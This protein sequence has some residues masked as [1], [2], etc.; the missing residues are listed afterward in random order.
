MRK[1][2][3][4]IIALT[5]TP[6]VLLTAAPAHA[7]DA[8]PTNNLSY[9]DLMQ[10]PPAVDEATIYCL[11]GHLEQSNATVAE[12]REVIAEQ[13]ATIDRLQAANARLAEKFRNRFGV[14]QGLRDEVRFLRHEL[15]RLRAR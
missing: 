11:A 1:I 9:C 7:S 12:Q 6:A 13:Q 4:T 3:S 14:V 2:I 8:D 5:V 10:D 15:R